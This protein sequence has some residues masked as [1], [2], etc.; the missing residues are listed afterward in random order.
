MFNPKLTKSDTFLRDRRPLVQ[1]SLLQYPEDCLVTAMAVTVT[2]PLQGNVTYAGPS[3]SLPAFA[4]CSQVLNSRYGVIS[5]H[6]ASWR[7]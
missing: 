2:V 3:H 4:A 5:A 6:S 7:V 1:I